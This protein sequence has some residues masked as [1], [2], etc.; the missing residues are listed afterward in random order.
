MFLFCDTYSITSIIRGCANIPTVVSCPEVCRET[1]APLPSQ[2]YQRHPL[3]II[4]KE[5]SDIYFIRYFK[6]GRP[7]PA[8]QD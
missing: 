3:N 1:E 7:A 4:Q 6:A 8:L 2:D 5:I